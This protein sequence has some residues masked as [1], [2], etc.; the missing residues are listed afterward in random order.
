[1]FDEILKTGKRFFSEYFSCSYRNTPENKNKLLNIS[2]VISKKV[3]KKAVYRNRE[4]R[5][6]REICKKTSFYNKNFSG[7]LI[8]FIKKPTR[9][10]PFH[11][12][13]EELES[14]LKKIN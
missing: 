2:V 3:V 13:Q 8:L 11:I 10:I 4:K 6:I 12:L 9:E 14:L 7:D 5:R 1:M